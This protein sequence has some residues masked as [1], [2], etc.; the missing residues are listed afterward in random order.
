MAGATYQGLLQNSM[1]DPYIIGVSAG[2]SLGAT[3]AILL[4]TR[5]I[6][7]GLSFVTLLAFL[8][9]VLT[10]FLVYNIA[11]V[12][13]RVPI[14]TLLLAGVA[15]SSFFSAVVSFLMVVANQSMP[16]IVYWMM[17]SLS[18]R[19]W[20][21][22]KASLPYLALGGLVVLFYSR[23]LNILLGGRA[24]SLGNVN[25]WLFSS[26]PLRMAA[27]TVSVS[28]VIGFVVDHSHS[29]E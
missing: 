12:G 2:A 11:R 3:I 23:E 1:A 6:N 24:A 26:L 19:S 9:A 15:V 5:Y 27:A 22:V 28:G 20:N 17:G 7:L 10:I 13:G 25:R 18:G 8:G 4:R 29:V 21:H 14:G 16:E